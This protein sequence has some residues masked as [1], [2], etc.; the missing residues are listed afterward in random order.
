VCIFQRFLSHQVP[1][2]NVA[3]VRQQIIQ[4]DIL[5]CIHNQNKGQYFFTINNLDFDECTQ[6]DC[7]VKPYLVALV[8]NLIPSLIGSCLI[9]YVEVSIYYIV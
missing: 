8:L 5:F 1:D 3:L 9:V 2:P 4:V 6:K 7:M